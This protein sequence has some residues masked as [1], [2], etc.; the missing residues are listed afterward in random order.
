VV[1]SSLVCRAAAGPR[2]QHSWLEGIIARLWAT[3]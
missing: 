1:G 3:E 2:R